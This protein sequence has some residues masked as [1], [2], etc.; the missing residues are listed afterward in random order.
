MYLDGQL[1]LGPD[2]PNKYPPEPTPGPISSLDQV[3]YLA[4]EGG[5][6]IVSP[7]VATA[8]GIVQ[9]PVQVP[10]SRFSQ[11]RTDSASYSDCGDYAAD[12]SLVTLR[13]QAGRGM[14]YGLKGL[15]DE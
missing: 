11:L 3:T 9:T 10:R 8:N 6:A 4:P 2:S 15:G 12:G 1:P 14:G 7:T 5:A 13:N